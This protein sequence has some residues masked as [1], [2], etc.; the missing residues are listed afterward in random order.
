MEREA[1][2]GGHCVL[3]RERLVLEHLGETVKDV[4]TFGREVFGLVNDVP[5]TMSETIALDDVMLAR[6][7]AVEAVA[8]LDRRRKVSTST[9]EEIAEILAGVLTSAEEERDRPRLRE[10]D[11]RRRE[12]A[13]ALRMGKLARGDELYAALAHELEDSHGGV[14]VVN[15]AGLSGVEAERKPRRLDGGDVLG[16]DSRSRRPAG[17]GR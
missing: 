7:V 5:P 8:H 14:V 1:L 10:G 2:I 11:D 6:D 13:S 17:G 9:V 3:H 16:D 4:A 12:Q 15:D